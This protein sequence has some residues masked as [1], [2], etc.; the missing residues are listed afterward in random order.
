M[1]KLCIAYIGHPLN[2]VPYKAKA[3][4]HTH[5]KRKKK[6]QRPRQQHKIDE[7]ESKRTNNN[8]KKLLPMLSVTAAHHSIQAYQSLSSVVPL[9]IPYKSVRI[10]F[11]FSL[12]LSRLLLALFLC[13][14][15]WWWC[16][17]IVL[18]FSNENLISKYN[19]YI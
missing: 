10:F 3:N 2:Y 4:R 1:A 6:Q 12:S 8:N 15:V 19:M 18:L 13:K 7:R 16:Q 9:F 17:F 14:C 11:R 5:T